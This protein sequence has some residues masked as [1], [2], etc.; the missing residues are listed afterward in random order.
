[1]T[2]SYRHAYHAGSASDVF[3]HASLLCLLRLRVEALQR[4]RGAAAQLALVDTHSGAGS[5]ELCAGGLAD[6]LREHRGG[7]A[8]LLEAVE[9]RPAHGALHRCPD[10]I[11]L[12]RLARE[13]DS[14]R[15]GERD[16][17][18]RPRATATSMTSL[19]HYPGSP[20]LALAF[21][22]RACGLKGPAAL[23]ELHSTDQ[24]LLAS[25]VRL[26]G[27]PLPG[28]PVDVLRADGFAAA[29][30]AALK[31][32]ARGF[33]ISL[34]CDPAYELPSE[35]A[36]AEQL[37][38]ALAL[39][40]AQHQHQH[41]HWQAALWYPRLRQRTESDAMLARLRAFC[42]RKRLPWASLVLDTDSARGAQ[43]G[44]YGSGLFVAGA[45][46]GFA[47][48]AKYLLPAL[49]DVLAVHPDARWTVEQGE[50][51]QPGPGPG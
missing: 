24:P 31:L 6:K 43:R 18:A 8:R 20:L 45:P 11:E 42:R 4:E 41:M 32:A 22:R 30:A 28:E 48:E 13:W 37:V 10:A 49:R 21:V 25:N 36:R 34:L 46:P 27:W 15:H 14:H 16:D 12:A 35:Y 39:A 26:A 19:Q 47:S 51:G 29:P 33:F 38:R 7:V 1:M 23:F 40:L 3:K 9:R 44:L 17:A 50:D 2:L 5:Y